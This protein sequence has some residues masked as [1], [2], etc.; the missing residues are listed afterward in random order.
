MSSVDFDAPPL[1]RRPQQEAA[2]SGIIPT[3]SSPG[4]LSNAQKYAE[5]NSEDDGSLAGDTEAFSEVHESD[6]GWDRGKCG[7]K[8]GHDVFL[9]V[10]YGETV[11]GTEFG[12]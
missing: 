6:D 4:P 3:S 5:D 10:D 9:S 11:T 2:R 1:Y 12:K 7:D 8:V